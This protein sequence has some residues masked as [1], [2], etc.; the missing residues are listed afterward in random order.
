MHSSLSGL[1]SL[2]CITVSCS[3]L[4]P[5][6]AAPPARHL[7]VSDLGGVVHVFDVS[8]AAP[9]KVEA[10]EV[11]EPI[12]FLALHPETAVLYALGDSAL[13]A[14]AIGDDGR[15]LTAAGS[16]PLGLRGTH[17]EIDLAG[18]RAYVASYGGAA[19]VLVELG[20]GGAP[21]EVLHVVGGKGD[22]VFDRAHQVRLHAPSGTIHVPCLGADHVAHLQLD[23]TR[24]RLELHC[25]GATPEGAGPRHLDYHPGLERAYALNELQSSVTTFQVLD[26]GCL[27]PESTTTTLPPGSESASRSSDIHVGVGGEFLFAMNRE[28]LNDLVVFALDEQG[29][30]RYQGRM[31]TGGDHA[32][33]FALDPAG[34]RLW[35][36]STR[37]AELLAVALDGPGR[38][39]PLPPA[40]KGPDD[41]TCVLAR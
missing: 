31:P 30:P 11:G 14:F 9:E 20:A 41:L 16:T 35:I 21:G 1:L 38:P 5:P 29:E 28:P 18:D 33:T 17:V 39:R 12:R 36:A 26:G 34:G 8:G 22:L 13:H 19:V 7:F 2:L 27:R 4:P 32:R 24:T 37:S 6:D 15:S 23:A 10:V 40:W 25:M 3:T